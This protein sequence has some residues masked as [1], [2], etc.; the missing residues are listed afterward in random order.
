[1]CPN[2]RDNSFFQHNNQNSAPNSSL[3][4]DVSEIALEEHDMGVMVKVNKV[5]EEIKVLKHF[6]MNQAKTQ[7]NYL[8]IIQV[9]ILITTKLANYV[10]VQISQLSNKIRVEVLKKLLP[11]IPE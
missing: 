6:K 4:E 3:E 8:A 1:M 11:L 5:I 2:P 10:I 7:I 9:Q